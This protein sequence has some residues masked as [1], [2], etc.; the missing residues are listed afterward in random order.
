MTAGDQPRIELDPAEV[1]RAA[2]EGWVRN[3][4]LVDRLSRPAREW[5]VANIGPKPGDTVLELAAGAGDTGFDTAERIGP[6]GRLISSDIAPVMLE[7]G[8]ERAAR[9][10]LANVEF[11]EI[12][13]QAIGL[14]DGSVDAVVH[15]FGPMLLPE[16][17]ASFREVRRVLR[18]GGRY[19]CAVWGAPEANPWIPMTGMPLV[20]IGLQPPGDP[21]VPGGLFSLADPEALERR[22]RDA[23]FADVRV[24]AV[25]QTF[26]FTDFDELWRIPSEVAGPIAVIVSQLDEERRSAFRD[27][28]RSL[29]DTYR[30]GSGGYRVPSEALCVLAS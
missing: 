6:E 14:E 29:A 24:E 12:D 10:G 3:A 16:P 13:A 19:A 21:F 8:R 7:A 25:P 15:R 28:F 4:D 17:D 1:W 26:S 5:I 11:R 22:V 30:T 23:G 9:R 18:P 2:A 20:Q 27:G